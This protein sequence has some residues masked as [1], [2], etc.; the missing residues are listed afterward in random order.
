MLFA[1]LPLRALA[2]FLIK[3]VLGRQHPGYFCHTKLLFT[4]ERKTWALL[5]AKPTEETPCSS[6]FGFCRIFSISSILYTSVCSFHVLTWLVT[7]YSTCLRKRP[8]FSGMISIWM[9]SFPNSLAS[10]WDTVSGS[11][12]E[13]CIFRL[14]R[15]FGSPSTGLGNSETSQEG[16]T[17]PRGE[18]RGDN[19]SPDVLTTVDLFLPTEAEAMAV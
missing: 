19:V 16:I 10:V 1:D 12:W 7:W 8:F 14:R 11:S 4:I 13:A 2:N 5:P 17:T 6:W 18:G 3:H 15:S 9:V